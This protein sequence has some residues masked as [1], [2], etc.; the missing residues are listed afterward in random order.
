MDAMIDFSPESAEDLKARYPLAL[1]PTYDQREVAA[2]L[3]RPPSG[4]AR[5]VF[6][7]R[8]GL[9]LIV[10][11]ELTPD[12]IAGI[13]ISASMIS[14]GGDMTKTIQY[15]RGIAQQLSR[16]KAE[17]RSTINLLK[18]ERKR[19][20]EYR[21]HK[22]GLERKLERAMGDRRASLRQQA[23]LA[24]ALAVTTKLLVTQE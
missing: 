20:R 18:I 7:F 17:L 23:R 12:L 21:E 15:W 9:R 1:T 13:H 6:D 24:E 10:S 5:H 19:S 11:H 16:S 3:T 8:T 22:Y 14:S 4:I 2:G